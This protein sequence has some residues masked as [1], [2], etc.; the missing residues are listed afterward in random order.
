MNPTNFSTLYGRITRNPCKSKNSRTI[1]ST[2]KKGLFFWKM[3][4]S[5]SAIGEVSLNPN[6][7]LVFLLIVLRLG[8]K[9]K[10]INSKA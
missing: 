5:A 9:K 6:D 8:G 4:F 10:R 1:D 3:C 2:E 7:S